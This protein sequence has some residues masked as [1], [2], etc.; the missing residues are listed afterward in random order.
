MD[1]AEPLGVYVGTN[2]G[3]VFYSR[4]EGDEWHTLAATL[5]PVLSVEARAS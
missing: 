5:P 1:G 2:T 3:Q 4:D